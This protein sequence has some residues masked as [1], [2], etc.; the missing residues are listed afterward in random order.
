MKK[1]AASS[2]WRKLGD[3]NRVGMMLIP[4]QQQERFAPF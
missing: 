1:Y 3:G 2:I 4:T